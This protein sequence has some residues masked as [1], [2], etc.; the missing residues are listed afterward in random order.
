MTHVVF[1]FGFYLTGDSKSSKV[2]YDFRLRNGREL[3]GL[4][5]F[6]LSPKIREQKRRVLK[7]KMTIYSHDDSHPFGHS[8]SQTFGQ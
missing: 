1:L 4:D 8:N 5:F 2:I 3:L 7:V 6:Y